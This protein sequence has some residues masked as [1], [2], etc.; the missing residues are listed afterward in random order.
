M[1]STVGMYLR[2]TGRTNKD[3]SVVRYLQLTHNER[4]PVTGVSTAKVI[5]HFGRADQ[6]DREGLAG[7]LPRS[8]SF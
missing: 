7:R 4:N 8:R 2:E 6:V 1:C 3:D 5:H